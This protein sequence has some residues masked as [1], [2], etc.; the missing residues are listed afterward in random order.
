MKKASATVV[1]SSEQKKVF[2]VSI[3]QDGKIIPLNN[4]NPEYTTINSIICLVLMLAKNN[5][6]YISSYNDFGVT[7]YNIQFVDIDNPSSINKFGYIA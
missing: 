4:A 7:W 5:G 3:V 1:Y 2:N 6:F